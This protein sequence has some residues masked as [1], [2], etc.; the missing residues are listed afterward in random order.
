MGVGAVVVER[1][2]LLLVQRGR[3]A[4]AGCWAVPG[5]RQR[6]GELLRET[7]RRETREETGL[8]IEVGPVL[9][10]GDAIDDQVPPRWHFA[11]VDFAAEVVGGTL[12][13]GDDAAAARWV[14]PAEVRGLDLTPTMPLL[15]DVLDW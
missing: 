12:A 6:F 1:G 11:L 8:E 9:W 14:S 4:F 2:R 10:V 3:G 15:L 5:G 13:A 7:A